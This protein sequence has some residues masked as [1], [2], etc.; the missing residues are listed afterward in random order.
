VS[1]LG[2]GKQG[3]RLPVSGIKRLPVDPSSSIGI[4][5]HLEVFTE[6]FVA[7]RPALL[8]EDL[9]LFA[10][11]RIAF[12]SRRVVGLLVR[13]IRPDTLGLLRRR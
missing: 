12:E 10:H 1:N 8:E 3:A 6:F 9:D 5:L 2:H 7:H 13:D 4:A 11:E